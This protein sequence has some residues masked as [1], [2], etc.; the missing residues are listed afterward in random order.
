MK[1]EDAFSVVEVPSS[2]ADQDRKKK[3]TMRLPSS[4]QLE[5]CTVFSLPLFF[6]IRNCDNFPNYNHR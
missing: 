4:Q 6:F 5:E 3:T 2:G 1:D